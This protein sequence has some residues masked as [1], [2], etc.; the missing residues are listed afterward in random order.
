MAGFSPQCSMKVRRLHKFLGQIFPTNSKSNG[1]FALQNQRA[2]QTFPHKMMEHGLKIIKYIFIIFFFFQDFFCYP[3]LFQKFMQPLSSF[4]GI[5]LFIYRIVPSMAI[6][7]LLM[8]YNVLCQT[9]QLL[10]SAT[11]SFW[12]KVTIC[13]VYYEM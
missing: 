8:A 4:F 13:W 9:K 11:C 7:M 3:P 10:L 6:Q 12:P 5:K 2:M 1:D